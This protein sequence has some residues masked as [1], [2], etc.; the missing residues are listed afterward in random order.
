VTLLQGRDLTH[1]RS[2]YEEESPVSQNAP[3]QLLTLVDKPN[4]FRDWQTSVTSFLL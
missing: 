1:A 2:E 3:P 4:T